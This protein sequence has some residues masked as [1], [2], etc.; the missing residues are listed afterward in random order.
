MESISGFWQAIE[1]FLPTYKAIEVKA[2]L[3][4]TTSTVLSMVT[5]LT[6]E[7][8]ESPIPWDGIQGISFLVESYPVSALQGLLTG[9]EN[10]SVRFADRE[11]STAD[12]SIQIAEGHGLEEDSSTS[13]FGPDDL[14]ASWPEYQQRKRFWLQLNGARRLEDVL[15]PREPWRIARAVGEQ[16]FSELSYNRVGLRIG[17]NMYASRIVLYA[18]IFATILAKAEYPAPVGGIRPLDS[19]PA[20]TI[21]VD[22]SPGFEVDDFRIAYYVQ[23]GKGTQI[24]RE[25]RPVDTGIKD[26]LDPERFRFW[27][28]ELPGET[29]R[30]GAYLYYKRYEGDQEPLFST[31]FTVSQE[32]STAT[33]V[34]PSEELPR[35]AKETIIANE[36]AMLVEPIWKGRNFDVDPK[37][38]F[39]L[40]PFGEPFDTIYRD[41]I[42]KTVEGVGLTCLRADDVYGVS[43]VMED[44]WE[45]VCKARVL[46]AELTGRNPNVFYELGMAHCLGK[47]VTL[48]TQNPDD[49][50]FDLRHLRYIH[51]VYTPPGANQL[52]DVLDKTLRTV[53][54]RLV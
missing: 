32:V 2:I 48:I 44:I 22:L 33:S 24:V 45:H 8:R 12:F 30:G 17:D 35:D 47:E 31:R 13:Q 11:Y 18:P 37:L 1:P 16:R 21:F 15:R 26:P 7:A 5:C 49:V 36:K 54:G 9:L 42:K 40:M 43:A 10:G 28:I 19:R 25:S 14:A 38:C 53:V 29:V 41:H 52:V 39:V 3:D 6:D 20:M 34:V 46:I 23:N 50:P 27:N 51:Y 4:N